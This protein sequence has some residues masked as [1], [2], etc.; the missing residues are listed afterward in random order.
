MSEI[1]R[2]PYYRVVQTAG[3]GGQFKG[4]ELDEELVLLDP[5]AELEL[6]KEGK[7]NGTA[8]GTG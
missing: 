4:R 1:L 5:V 8:L 2:I 7:G 6:G 3:A